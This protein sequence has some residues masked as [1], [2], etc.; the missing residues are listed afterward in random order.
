MQKLSLDQ[1]AQAKLTIL[2]KNALKQARSQ[3]NSIPAL[4]KLAKTFEV[5]GAKQAAESILQYLA[6]I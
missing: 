2:L 1:K 3:E 6:E 5:G 4:A